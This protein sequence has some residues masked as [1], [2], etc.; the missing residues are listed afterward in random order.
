MDNQLLLT[1]IFEGTGRSN[2]HVSAI[3]ISQSLESWEYQHIDIG[4]PRALK[5]GGPVLPGPYG[6]CAYVF[7]LLLIFPDTGGWVL[8]YTQE[9]VSG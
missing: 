3:L 4:G 8:A 2:V 6:G 9:P 1:T 5:V 7:D